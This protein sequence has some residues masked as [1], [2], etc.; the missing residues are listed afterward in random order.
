MPRLCVLVMIVS[1][2]PL[3]AMKLPL[4]QVV[5]AS[6]AASLASNGQVSANAASDHLIGRRSS[7]NGAVASFLHRS[8]G[9][10]PRESGW[11]EGD[12]D[13]YDGHHMYGRNTVET[14]TSRPQ[15]LRERRFGNN[16]VEGPHRRPGPYSL[17][18][19]KG[20]FLAFTLSL[21]IHGQTFIGLI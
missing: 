3:S 18:H 20:S 21:L 16:E 12:G 5:P 8:K 6:N 14:N 7:V 17:A 15:Y 10:Q 19:R 9:L 11:F 4:M 1:V 2:K 13:Q